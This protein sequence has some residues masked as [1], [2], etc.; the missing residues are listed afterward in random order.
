[1]QLIVL[2]GISNVERRTRILATISD[3]GKVTT[4]AYR[5]HV[6]E[7][8][9]PMSPGQILN[10]VFGRCENDVNSSFLHKGI[11]PISVE[12]DFCHFFSFHETFASLRARSS[13][14][15]DRRFRLEIRR[16]L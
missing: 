5:I 4:D 15:V 2:Q 1:F 7:P 12:R 11:E 6:V 3:N 14:R 9:E 10:V 16:E 13:R 8:K